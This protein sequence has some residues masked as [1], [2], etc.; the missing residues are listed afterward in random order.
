MSRNAYGWAAQ[1]TQRIVY[2]A[3]APPAQRELPLRNDPSPLEL[4]VP[5]TQS[6]MLLLAITAVVQIGRIGVV[7]R[8]WNWA[9]LWALVAVVLAR[10]LPIAPFWSPL[11]A[12]GEKVAP[13]FQVFDVLALLNPLAVAFLGIV[14]IVLGSRTELR[15]VPVYPP[16]TP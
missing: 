4:F 9:P 5:V 11:L 3:L 1:R 10:A 7:P 13:P 16:A 6:V 15:P 12:S 14:A 2:S 8:P